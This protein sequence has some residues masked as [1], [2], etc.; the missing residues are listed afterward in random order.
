M[1]ALVGVYLTP[2]AL[3]VGD[4]FPVQES[5]LVFGVLNTSEGNPALVLSVG[6]T[7]R[8]KEPA[9]GVGLL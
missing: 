3:G 4:K 1:R 7:I 6:A 5:R 9:G 2:L 8:L